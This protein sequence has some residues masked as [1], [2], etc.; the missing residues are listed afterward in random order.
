M[1]KLL[2]RE[3]KW[4][5]QD[6]RPTE[7]HSFDSN[8]DISGYTPKPSFSSMLFKTLALCHI[9]PKRSY[10]IQ[11]VY[12]VCLQS[13]EAIEHSCL[14]RTQRAKSEFRVPSNLFMSSAWLPQERQNPRALGLKNVLIWYLVQ[15]FHF[16]DDETEVWGVIWLS[17][18]HLH[19]MLQK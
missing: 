18:G 3:I 12:E 13:L 1:K 16:R 5:T 2:F 7:W 10:W 14:K 6:H 9:I 19:K 11:Q 4:L 8:L 15:C 17:Q